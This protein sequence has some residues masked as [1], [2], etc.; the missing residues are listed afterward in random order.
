[1]FRTNETKKIRKYKNTFLYSAVLLVWL[2]HVENLSL[3]F[4]FVYFEC[5]F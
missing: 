1:M 3:P 4:I 2:S 5:N